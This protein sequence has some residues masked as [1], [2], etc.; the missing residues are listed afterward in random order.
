MARI[1]VEALQHPFGARYL[2]GA[3]RDEQSQMNVD[4]LG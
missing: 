2:D 4:L 1:F 3:R